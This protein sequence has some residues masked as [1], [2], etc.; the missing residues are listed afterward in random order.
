MTDEELVEY[1]RLVKQLQRG[2]IT[3]DEFEQDCK[4]RF[5]KTPEQLYTEAEQETK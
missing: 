2:I 5:N 3:D 1:R 4:E